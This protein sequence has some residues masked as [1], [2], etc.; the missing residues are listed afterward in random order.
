MGIVQGMGGDAADC[1]EEEGLVERGNKAKKLTAATPWATY[2]RLRLGGVEGWGVFRRIG[3]GQS[4][5]T[6]RSRGVKLWVS[7]GSK[8]Q[9]PPI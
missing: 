3:F 1:G 9:Q 7:V 6:G 4:A 5:Q 2:K 8:R